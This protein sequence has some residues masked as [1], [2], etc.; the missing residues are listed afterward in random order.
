M[1]YGVPGAIGAQLAAPDRM[2]FSWVGDGGFLM[3]GQEAAAIV[4]ENLPVKIIVC[5]N[6]AWG[7][8]LVHQ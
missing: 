6:A 4:Q 5:D 2:V 1:G 3:T 7:S 8:I